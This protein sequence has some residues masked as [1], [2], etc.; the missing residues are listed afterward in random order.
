MLSLLGNTTKR[1]LDTSSTSYTYPCS[2]GKH[3]P[4]YSPAPNGEAVRV[5]ELPFATGRFQITGL[6]SR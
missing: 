3:D 5:A 2:L 6:T 1:S 4:Q